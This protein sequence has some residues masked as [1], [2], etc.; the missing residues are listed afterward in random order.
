M[1]RKFFDKSDPRSCPPNHANTM[2]CSCGH[3][4]DEACGCGHAHD[5]HAHDAPEQASVLA[6]RRAFAPASPVTRT[7]LEDAAIAMLQT[8]GDACCIDGILPGHAKALVEC[9]EGAF[10]LSLT[11]ADQVDTQALGHWNALTQIGTFTVTV[12]V[13]LLCGKSVEEDQ[14]FT[15]FAAL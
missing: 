15:P 12:N 5:D 13:H 6:A 1:K 7:A 10:S 8:V 2:P 14:L 4:H 11:I 3:T 9:A